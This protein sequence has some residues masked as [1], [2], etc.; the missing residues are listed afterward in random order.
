MINLL[1]EVKL[2]DWIQIALLCVAAAALFWTALELREQ[3]RSRDFENYLLLWDKYTEAWRRFG[4]AKED[5]RFFEF[6]ELMDLLDASCNFYNNGILRRSTREMVGGYLTGILPDIFDDPTKQEMLI[7]S[8]EDR[9]TFSEIVKFARRARLDGTDGF[10]ALIESGARLE[11]GSANAPS[12]KLADA[13][14]VPARIVSVDALTGFRLNVV[15]TDGTNSRVD[16]SELVDD[17]RHF[18]SFATNPSAFQTV[19]VVGSGT[20]IGW[21]NG[22]DISAVTLVRLAKSASAI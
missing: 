13:H 1:G 15:W 10:V 9:D 5:D 11:S 22:L 6:V 19:S 7:K 17:S 16:L 4:N 18:A 2:S 8:I 14:V 12:P 20:G 3:V 21:Q